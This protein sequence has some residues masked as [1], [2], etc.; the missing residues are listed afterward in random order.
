MNGHSEA[1]A[2]IQSKC[3]G[4]EHKQKYDAYTLNYKYF[5][6]CRVQYNFTH[7]RGIYINLFATEGDSPDNTKIFSEKGFS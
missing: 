5:F 1:L 7:L 3:K 6:S 4:A 2:E